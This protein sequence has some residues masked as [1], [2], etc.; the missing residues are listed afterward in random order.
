MSSRSIYA[1]NDAMQVIVLPSI[2][3]CLGALALLSSGF[4]TPA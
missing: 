1:Q 3:N 2:S 4:A